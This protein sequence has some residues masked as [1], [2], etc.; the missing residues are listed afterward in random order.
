MSVPRDLNKV[1]NLNTPPLVLTLALDLV[2][3]GQVLLVPGVGMKRKTLAF[4][5]MNL[6]SRETD[7][8][9]AGG[10]SGLY[11]G[12]KGATFVGEI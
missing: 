6:T 3:P 4:A 7:L 5:S 1:E 2:D 9:K 11:L 8:S 10:I 12:K